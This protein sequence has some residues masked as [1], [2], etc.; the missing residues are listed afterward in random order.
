[1]LRQELTYEDFNGDTVTD[2][3]YFNLTKAELLEMEA[4][5]AGGVANM[6][7]RIVEARDSNAIL[8][9]I[10]DFVLNAYGVK[11]EDG[12]RFI[13]T[14]ELR[15]EFKQSQAYSD[16]LMELVGDENKL[17]AWF[18]GTFPKDVSEGMM[19]A[20]KEEKAKEPKSP[21]PPPSI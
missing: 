19:Q 17:I 7:N 8:Q 16:L 18:A 21:P 15:E 14:D 1:V 3:L 5:A 2:V 11:S 6:F 10:Q 20:V 13:K 12:K 9:A 4:S